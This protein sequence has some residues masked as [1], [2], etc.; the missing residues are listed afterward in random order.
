[1]LAAITPATSVRSASDIARS[2]NWLA[3][4]S[5]SPV[6]NSGPLGHGK[7]YRYLRNCTSFGRFEVRYLEEML[8][9]AS[10]IT[11]RTFCLHCDWREASKLF[12]YDTHPKQGGL[13][14]KND[15][16]VTYH[17]SW[18]KGKRCYFI[19]HSSIE[20][21]FVREDFRGQ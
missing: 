17:R 16:A 14:L 10:E 13:M 15:W 6:K 20:Y 12:G 3:R 7:R 4:E 11:Y 5:G 1:M 18:Y 2:D 21:I 8:D 19:C 9:K